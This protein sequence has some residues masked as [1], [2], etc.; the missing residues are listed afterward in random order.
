MM[1]LF[2]FMS[3]GQS[4]SFG[5]S[6]TQIIEG[7]LHPTLHEGCHWQGDGKG[8]HK[9]GQG[10]HDRMMMAE[11][12]RREVCH[13]PPSQEDQGQ[14]YQIEAEG[15]TSQKPQGSHL[16][17]S[18]EARPVTGN[19]HR[20]KPCQNERSGDQDALEE[21]CYHKKKCQE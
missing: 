4:Q 14:V 5:E 3:L 15:N 9:K 21:R 19:K 6:V 10:R 11:Q 12:L 16:Q 8:T 18:T 13:Q 20:Q 2:F 17:N 1:S 7:N